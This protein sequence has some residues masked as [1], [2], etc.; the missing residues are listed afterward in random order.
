LTTLSNSRWSP[1]GHR[2]LRR[3][4]GSPKLPRREVPVPPGPRRRRFPG[5]PLSFLLSTVRSRSCGWK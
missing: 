2:V 3:H 4:Q 5:E 1:E